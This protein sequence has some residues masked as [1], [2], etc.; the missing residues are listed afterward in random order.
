MKKSHLLGAVCAYSLTIISS[1]ASAALL[2]DQNV[3]P[4]VIFGSGNIN[5][6]FTV[7]Q[8]NNAELG[9]RAKLRYDATGQPQ[10]IFNSNGDGTY[11]FDAG[12]APTQ[13]SPTAI[14]SFEW[15]INSDLS[16]SA[17]RNLD[18][19]TYVL[20]IDSNPGVAQ[21]WS[22]FDP[23]NVADPDWFDHSIGDNTT[24]NGAGVEA[25][26]RASYLDLIA[27]NNVAQNSWKAHWFMPISFDPTVDGQYD[28]YLAAFNGSTQLARTEMSVIVG[29]GAVVP[30][31]A[32]VWLFGSGLLGL[33]G[34][35]R[36]KKA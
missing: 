31:P 12:V 35:A 20:G 24:L 14:W 25:T 9:L 6:S 26:D 2:Y 19:L 18:A 33:V 17:G 30:V 1:T 15:S 29:A 34:M 22:T 27:N 4:E 10:N 11:S 7:D 36:R 8:S 23:I 5:G 3:T 32:A 21:T 13:S 28:Y 16:G